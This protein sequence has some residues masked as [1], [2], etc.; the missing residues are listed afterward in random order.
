LS[1]HAGHGLTLAQ[2]ARVSPALVARLESYHS[3]RQ[4]LDHLN[5]PKAL[6]KKAAADKAFR[7]ATPPP[8]PP[9]RWGREH[10]GGASNYVF[11][12]HGV[13]GKDIAKG[14]GKKKRVRKV[15][16]MSRVVGG[17]DTH[18]TPNTVMAKTKQMLLAQLRAKK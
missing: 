12:E 7:Q 15:K 13:V 18:D 5:H 14:Q 11:H 1:N 3:V 10:S 9:P 4:A 6:G 8:P 2:V 17:H 16:Q